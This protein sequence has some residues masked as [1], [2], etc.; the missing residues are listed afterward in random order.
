MVTV[1]TCEC[2]CSNRGGCVLFLAAIQYETC[3]IS[4]VRVLSCA[5]GEKK[6]KIR[7]LAEWIK[8]GDKRTAEN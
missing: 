5:P 1:E 3:R 8:A 4:N 6:K 7:V 2:S